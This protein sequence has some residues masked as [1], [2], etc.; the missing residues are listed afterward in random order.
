MHIIRP[1]IIGLLA[2]VVV[3]ILLVSLLQ[4]M[5]RRWQVQREVSQLERE[6]QEMQ[7][8]VIHLKNLNQYFATDDYQ[9]RLAREKLNY[10]APGEKVVLIPENVSLTQS[11]E[12]T[13]QGAEKLSVPEQWWRAFFMPEE[14]T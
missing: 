13:D 8:S 3:F 9:E 12:P 2:F 11:G 7:R 14:T 1:R 6:V 4:E 10:Q 5:N